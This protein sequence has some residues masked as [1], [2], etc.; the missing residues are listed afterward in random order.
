[1]V[2]TPKCFCI[3]LASGRAT[4]QPTSQQ[5]AR[6]TVNA[7]YSSGQIHSAILTNTFGNME[8][9]SLPLKQVAVQHFNFAGLTVTATYSSGG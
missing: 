1:M 6:L 7:I 9:Y 4:F 2:L 5:F 8:K 3:C